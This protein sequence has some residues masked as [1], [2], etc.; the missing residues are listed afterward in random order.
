MMKRILCGFMM[1]VILLGVC[2]A[3]FAADEIKYTVSDAVYD[4]EAVTGKVEHVADTGELAKVYARVT[5]FYA[6]GTFA[7]MVVPVIDGEFFAGVLTATVHVAVQVVDNKK[8]VAPPKN[9][10]IYGYGVA[11]IEKK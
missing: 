5:L 2:S 9:D 11:A 6:D 1:A 3:A 8:Q 7:V 10:G 4:G